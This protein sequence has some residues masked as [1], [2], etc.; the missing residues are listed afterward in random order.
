MTSFT[1]ALT[2]SAEPELSYRTLRDE[3][4]SA[5]GATVTRAKR[6]VR[7]SNTAWT[8]HIDPDEGHRGD[9]TVALA[10]T[11]SCDEPR[12]CLHLRCGAAVQR[13]RLHRPRP[14]TPH[15]PPDT[16]PPEPTPPPEPTHA[17]RAP[18]RRRPCRRQPMP[19]PEPTPPP[20]AHAAAR[21]HATAG[22]HAAARATR[23]PITTPALTAVFAYAPGSHDGTN[24]WV[25]LEFSA[26]PDLRSR[27]LR[28]EALS[29]TGATPCAPGATHAAATARGTSRSTP[30]TATAATSPSPSPHSIL[31]RPR[32]H[33]HPRRRS[34]VDRRRRHRPRPRQRTTRHQ[35]RHRPAATTT[36]RQT[37]TQTPTPRSSRSPTRPTS[38]ST[39]SSTTPTATTDPARSPSPPWSP[40]PASSNLMDD[41][42]RRLGPTRRRRPRT[43]PTLRRQRQEV[44]SRRSGPGRITG[45]W[46]MQWRIGSTGTWQGVAHNI[47]TTSCTNLQG[48]RTNTIFGLWDVTPGTT[49]YVRVRAWN[50]RSR[51]Q[52]M[53]RRIRHHIRLPRPTAQRD[54]DHF[55]WGHVRCCLGPRLRTPAAPPS[56][57]TA[58]STAVPASAISRSPTYTDTTP[59]RVLPDLT[60]G[61]DWR[62]TV[63]SHNIMT[64]RS[65]PAPE[66][67]I[68][69][70]RNC[71]TAETPTPRQPGAHGRRPRV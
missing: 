1:V 5:T 38:T 37:A 36:G 47:A 70:R 34:P 39:T 11:A 61:T 6:Q 44:A 9:I 19:P 21:A 31:R 49:I 64:A 22:A 51:R 10:A 60:C 62:I 71:L 67:Q 30:M 58:C 63:R 59:H 55:Q 68:T 66:T 20:R 8:I 24:F 32:R 33:L 29:V 3:A 17:A 26:E 45:P 54:R 23:R 41:T 52:R 50:T 13:R 65:G 18:C 12:R 2:F 15:T 57:G 48:S 16:T 56:R 4:I 69:Y 27:A 35:H 28:D 40:T 43:E 25:L 14:P 53:R 46:E 7:G 42:R